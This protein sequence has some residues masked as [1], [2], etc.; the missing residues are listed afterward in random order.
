MKGIRA[1]RNARVECASPKQVLLMVFQNIVMRL[2]QGID[3]FDDGDTDIFVER[4]RL[5][6][7]LYGELLVALDES[8]APDLCA[9]LSRLYTWAI[10][11]LAE[12][13]RERDAKNL[14]DVLR[15]SREL[16]AG[17]EVAVNSRDAA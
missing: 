1:Y 17:W 9:R 14:P 16:L 11:Q 4:S 8:H 13:E 2:E 5:V 7:R 6:R 15:I 10:R 3:A 12:A